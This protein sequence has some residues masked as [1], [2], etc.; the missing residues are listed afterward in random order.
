MMD[1]RDVIELIDERL[2]LALPKADRQTFRMMRI[3]PFKALDDDDVALE[4]VGV[5]YLD[6]ELNFVAIKERDGEIYPLL[7]SGVYREKA[8]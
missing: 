7:V 4:V 1:E 2:D 5:S 3:A 8:A 6:D